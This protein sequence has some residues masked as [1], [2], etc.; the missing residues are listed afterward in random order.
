[1][2]G[3]GNGIKEA[4]RDG[5]VR[6]KVRRAAAVVF[7]LL[8]VYLLASATVLVHSLE[9]DVGQALEAQLSSERARSAD[10]AKFQSQLAELQTQLTQAQADLSAARIEVESLRGQLSRLGI[11][12]ETPE[13]TSSEAAARTPKGSHPAPSQESASGPA[14][15]GDA[16]DAPSVSPQPQPSR[17]S[18]PPKPNP[19]PMLC[20]LLVSVCL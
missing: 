17:P 18:L 9:H 20:L 16:A 2:G 7:V 11:Q 8:G 19:D 3:R 15:G 1:M 14:V 6:P 4:E 12:P 5:V 13:P 10:A